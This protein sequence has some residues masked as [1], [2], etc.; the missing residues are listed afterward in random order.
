[1]FSAPVLVAELWSSARALS[2]TA[3]L[4]VRSSIAWFGGGRGGFAN[5]YGANTTSEVP[6]IVASVVIFAM[7][8]SAVAGIDNL[9]CPLLGAAQIV[10]PARLASSPLSTPTPPPPPPPC[11][12]GG[13]AAS[14]A[15]RRSGRRQGSSCS[16]G[17][18]PQGHASGLA[19]AIQQ[20]IYQRKNYPRYK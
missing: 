5:S 19:E 4:S 1:M 17:K 12:R 9:D 10:A 2:E 13:H 3:T 14:V 15:V 6:C 16:P 11:R 18:E 8:L 7:S 20:I